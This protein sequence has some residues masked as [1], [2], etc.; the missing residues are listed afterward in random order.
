MFSEVSQRTHSGIRPQVPTAGTCSL[1]QTFRGFVFSV[2]FAYSLTMSPGITSEMNTLHP[3]LYFRVC[4]W[5]IPKIETIYKNLE[6]SFRSFTCNPADLLWCR[7]LKVFNRISIRFTNSW[8]NSCLYSR[9][10]TDQ[11]EIGGLASY[12][13]PA[14]DSSGKR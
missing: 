4:F 11:E 8:K 10:F 1:M 2:S 5:G 12:E 3:N 6:S 13:W 7:P 9:A 14:T